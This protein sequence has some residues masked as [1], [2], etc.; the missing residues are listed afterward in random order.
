MTATQHSIVEGA[1][2]AGF[3]PSSEDIPFV[4]LFEEANTYLSNHL[5]TI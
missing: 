4:T 5:I 2:L 1:F 3:E